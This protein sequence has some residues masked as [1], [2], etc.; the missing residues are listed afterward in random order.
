MN[1]TGL[2][3]T[4]VQKKA[5]Y[6]HGSLRETLIAAAHDLISEHGVDGFTM[7]DACRRAGVSTAAPYR[8][9]AD[10]DELIDAVCSRGFDELS[11]LI[12][13]A[14][15]GH[16]AGSVD[17]IVAMGQAYV[18]FVGS[19]PQLFELMWVTAKSEAAEAVAKAEG[20]QCFAAL[21]EAVGAYRSAHHID[22]V[23]NEEIAVPLWTLVHGTA[24]LVLGERLAKMSPDEPVDALIERTTRTY[25]RGLE[26][27]T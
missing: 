14:R 17:S 21:L 12:V 20:Y 11:E 10:R 24:S 8:H 19:D 13:V 22:S 3:M 1:E 4:S 6:H 18:A 9:F 25:L 15:D 7:A 16:A 26:R 23:T 2:E 27:E 5:H